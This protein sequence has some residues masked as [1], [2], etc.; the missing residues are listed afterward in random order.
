MWYEIITGEDL[1]TAAIREV[2]EETGIEADFMSLVSFRHVHG[3]NFNCSDIYF[4]VHMHPKS[5]NITM[6]ERE[7]AA[8]EWMKVI[9]FF[10]FFFYLVMKL[11]LLLV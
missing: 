5:K 2:K 11:E 7:L 6:C 9:S 1:S 4:I 8:C 3:A 10:L